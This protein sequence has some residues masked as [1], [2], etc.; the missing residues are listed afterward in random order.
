LRRTRKADALRG[1]DEAGRAVV[2]RSAGFLLY[3]AHCG[4][5]VLT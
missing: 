1:A 3:T 2:E 5:E 4:T